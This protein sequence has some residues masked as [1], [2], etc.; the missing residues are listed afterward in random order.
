M[1]T[2]GL[3]E[4]LPTL[5]E[6]GPSGYLMVGPSDGKMVRRQ[7]EKTARRLGCLSRWVGFRYRVVRDYLRYYMAIPLG[8]RPSSWHHTP[9]AALDQ[10]GLKLLRSTYV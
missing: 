3:E 2:P 8:A 1:A 7:N 6:L 9:A 5:E 10:L 4:R